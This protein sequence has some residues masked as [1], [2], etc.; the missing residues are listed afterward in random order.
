MTMF[1][2]RISTGPEDEAKDI[3]APV[4][5]L[6]VGVV[7]IFIILILA[8]SL[9]LS[10]ETVVPQSTFDA[11]VAENLALTQQLAEAK[12]AF[13]AERSRRETAER[14]VGE[15]QVQEAKL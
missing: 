13:E 2:R 4:A 5:D 10:S 11:K 7:F 9:D 14:Q 8:L 3:F 1:N 6:M 15:L 12:A